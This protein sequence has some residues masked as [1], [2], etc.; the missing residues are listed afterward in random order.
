M[1]ED[2]K[3]GLWCIFL[4]VPGCG[5]GTQASLLVDAYGFDVISVGDILRSNK[6]M[7]I[8]GTGETVGEL[9]SSGALFPDSMIV[10]L[11][12]NELLSIGDIADR[13]IL[14]DG[15][16]RTVGQ[17]NALETLSHELGV[18]SVSVLNFVV[19]DDVVAKRILGRYECSEC[20]R[21]YNDFFLT[22]KVDGV[23]DYCGGVNFVRRSDDNDVSLQKRFLEYHEKTE[24]LIDYY[25]GLGVLSDL[26]ALL[27]PSEVSA[28]VADV[29]GLKKEK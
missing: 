25:K 17:G 20:G 11:V 18:Y 9:I 19:D 1:I 27:P 5:K 24:P 21:I 6:E 15:F 4:G 10:E 13:N 16:P 7:V 2:A 28:C 14:F 23:C 8:G 29:L 3:S 22:P 26:D 12:R